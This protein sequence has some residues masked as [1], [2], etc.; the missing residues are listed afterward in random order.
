MQS[1]PAV[2]FP[3]GRSHFQGWII[4]LAVLGGGV[5]GLVWWIQVD[6][7]G[8]RQGLFGLSY[9]ATCAVAGAVWLLSPQGVLRWDGQ[10]W[11]W[12]GE[13]ATHCGVLTVH[14]D[15]QRVLLVCLRS[16]SR[17]QLWLWPEHRNAKWSWNDLRRAVFALRG[18]RHGH[19]ATPETSVK[20]AVS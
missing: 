9:V 4:G 14:L 10:T 7:A 2:S 18:A 20:Q 19:D 12:T 6:H 8:W 1:A 17:A 15:L 3:V 11:T 13:T 16:E 5:I